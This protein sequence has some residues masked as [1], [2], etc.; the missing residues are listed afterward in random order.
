MLIFPATFTKR[1]DLHN[2]FG[3]VM[4]LTPS[5]LTIPLNFDL[6]KSIMRLMPAADGFMEIR[7]LAV[8][9][10]F[11]CWMHA[12]NTLSSISINRVYE[13]E[14]GTKRKLS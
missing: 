3:L 6:V 11:R 8:E 7:E 14:M 9:K 1:R 12:F 2:T 4:R 5:S 13:W 10:P